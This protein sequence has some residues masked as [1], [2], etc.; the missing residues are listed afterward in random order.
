MSNYTELI[1]KE[2]EGI[3]VDIEFHVD[4]VELFSRLEKLKT[5]VIAI[6]EGDEDE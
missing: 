4:E 3:M 1:V 2:L 5:F 6:D